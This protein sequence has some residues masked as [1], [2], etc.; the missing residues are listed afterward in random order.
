[1][2]YFEDFAPGQVLELGS[3][4][5]SRESMLAFAREFD[6]QSFHV[7]EEAARRSIYGGLLA[8]GWHTCSLWMRILCDGLLTDT[9]S[10]GSPGIDELRWLKPVRPGDTLSVRM[11]ILEAIPSRSKPDRGLLRSLTEMRN[12]HGEIVLTARGLSLL[13]R[14]PA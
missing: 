9:A 2:R 3:R 1:M 14:R 7:D 4:T 11:T 13:G 6:P 5:I 8:S 10:L 12:Q